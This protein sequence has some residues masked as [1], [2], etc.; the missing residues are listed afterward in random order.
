MYTEE[1]TLNKLKTQ[2]YSIKHRTCVKIHLHGLTK[3]L[4][5]SIVICMITNTIRLCLPRVIFG[6]KTRPENMIN[7]VQHAEGCEVHRMHIKHTH[8][9]Q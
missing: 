2:H 3:Q 8:Q 6:G 5:V 1:L 9:K 7:D 4:N